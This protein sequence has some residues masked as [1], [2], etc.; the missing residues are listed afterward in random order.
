M[1]ENGTEGK[2]AQRRISPNNFKAQGSNLK[3]TL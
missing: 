1:K 3:G 2:E